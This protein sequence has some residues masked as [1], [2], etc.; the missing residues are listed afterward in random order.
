MYCV[1]ASI[2]SAKMKKATNRR[3]RVLTNP[4]TTS[5]RTYLEQDEE[6]GLAFNI[7][8][9]RLCDFIALFWAQL[10]TVLCHGKRMITTTSSGN[11]R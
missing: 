1:L 6:R 10:A 4:A 11:K 8:A 2:A 9:S 3:N 5:A 7:A